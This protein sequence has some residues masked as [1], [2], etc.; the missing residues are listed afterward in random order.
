MRQ[1]AKP[2]NTLITNEEIYG[3]NRDKSIAPSISK[4]TINSAEISSSVEKHDGG[5]KAGILMKAYVYPNF[6]I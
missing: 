6:N 2:L 1:F 4:I 5:V 3:F